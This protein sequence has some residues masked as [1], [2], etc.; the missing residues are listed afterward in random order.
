MVLVTSTP[1]TAT[2]DIARALARL[3]VLGSLE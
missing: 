2:E 3:R 1:H